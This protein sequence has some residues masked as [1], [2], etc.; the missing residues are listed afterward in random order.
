MNGLTTRQVADMKGTTTRQVGQT[1]F[2]GQLPAVHIVRQ[3]WSARK[4][5]MGF[6]GNKAI[7]RG[8]VAIQAAYL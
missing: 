8:S 3:R 4:R 6:L 1:I 7:R 2:R 5:Q